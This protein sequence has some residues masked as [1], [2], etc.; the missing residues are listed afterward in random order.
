MLTFGMVSHDTVRKFALSFPGTDE[1]PHFHLTAFRV[2]KKIFSTLH[3]K[4]N[5][6]M[7]KLSLVDQS[8]FCSFDAKVI[9]PVPGGWGRQG[10][11]FIELATVKIAML[12]DAITTAYC[13][14]APAKLAEKFQKK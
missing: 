1:H 7:V 10:A 11:T 4:D 6:L 13:T 3:A 5:R 14:I 8:V 2:K 12:K 9:Y